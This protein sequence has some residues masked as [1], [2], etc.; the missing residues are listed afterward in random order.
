MVQAR[1]SE[2]GEYLGPDISAHSSHFCSSFVRFLVLN[3]SGLAL[4]LRLKSLACQ[5]VNL[6][7]NFKSLVDWNRFS[8]RIALYLASTS[9]FSVPAEG[10]TLPWH[11]AIATVL[12]YANGVLRVLLPTFMLY[13]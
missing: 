6:C 8:L 2:F 9:C 3:H 4:A 12:H 13:T 5:T 10:K 1:R 11:D 7:P